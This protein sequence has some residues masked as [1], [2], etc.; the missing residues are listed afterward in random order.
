MGRAVLALAV[1]LAAPHAQAAEPLEKASVAPMHAVGEHFVW[2]PD[3]LFAHSLLFDGDSGEV[4]ATID[5]GTTITPKPPLYSERRGEFYSVEIDYAR[6]TRG[7]RVDYVTIY[8]A[9]N[10]QVSGEVLIPTQTSESNASIAYSALLDGGR[11]LGTF[12]Q[13]PNTSISI[14]NLDRRSFAGEIPTTGCAGVYPTGERTLATLCGNGTVLAMTLDEAGSL[15]S[16]VAS[17][18]FF[19][20]V[21]D[22]VMMAGGRLESRWVFVSFA[23]KVHEVD[24]SVSPP[25]I[26]SWS[27][28]GDG[29]SGWRPG[30]L[31]HVALHRD[32]KRLYVILH[33]GGPGTH[34]DPGPEVWVFDLATRERVARFA[35]PNFTAA[36]LSAVLG[37]DA[38]SFT[39]WLLDGLLPGGG[40]HVIAVTQDD[41]PLLFARNA[42][43]GVVAVLD[44]NTGEHLRNLDEAGLGGPRLE[45]PR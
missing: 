42:E 41:T 7:K 34:K 11:F 9:T 40:A 17:A 13:F 45:V 36:F 43:R 30:G 20:V 10:L 18:P 33:E 27:L 15:E 29:D 35:M 31:Q 2:V 19:D 24:F 32:T 39:G 3:R 1:L 37:V 6:G 28:L 38:D 23:G 44:A 25:G 14:V 16:S 21:K 12:N 5:A 26:E 8:D 4:R 22:P